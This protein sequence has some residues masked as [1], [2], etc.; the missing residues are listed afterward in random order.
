MGAL[1]ETV[2]GQVPVHVS[3]LEGRHRGDF[4]LRLT[5]KLVRGNSGVQY[6][7]KELGNWQ[8]AGYQAEM[9]DALYGHT[10]MSG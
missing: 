2:P 8:I 4:E 3:Y 10:G 7:S 6:R 5:Y 1:W 9:S